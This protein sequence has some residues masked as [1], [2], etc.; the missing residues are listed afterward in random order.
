MIP[1]PEHD[2]DPPLVIHAHAL[3]GGPTS[4]QV[5]GRLD[6]RTA[7]VLERRLIEEARHC[8][9]QP[10]RLLLNLE[11]VTYLDRS[12]LDA[13][14]RT[15]SRLVS[16]FVTIELDAPTPSIIRL[17]HEANLDGASWMHRPR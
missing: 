10:A 11:G 1:T 17:L 12:G 15:S 8:R 5:V 13:L 7:P 16:G 9:I 6:R 4:L 3:L 14:L 2:A